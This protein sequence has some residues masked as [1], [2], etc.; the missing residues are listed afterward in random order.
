MK[1]DSSIQPESEYDQLV[2]VYLKKSTVSKIPSSLPS[3][4]KTKVNYHPE[5]RKSFGFNRMACEQC[6]IIECLGDTRQLQ[7]QEA[8]LAI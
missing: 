8:C 3:S 4:L 1:I 2:I 6:R 7:K 5:S